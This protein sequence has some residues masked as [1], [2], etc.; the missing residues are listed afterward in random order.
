[1]EVVFSSR[2]TNSG[3]ELL[4]IKT[5]VIKI[6]ID[7]KRLLLSGR[8][9]LNVSIFQQESLQVA[10]NWLVICQQTIMHLLANGN[11]T[12]SCL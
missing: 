8:L 2:H 4:T 9:P 3:F 11:K 12:S 6:N 7:M 1:M 5:I 10:Q